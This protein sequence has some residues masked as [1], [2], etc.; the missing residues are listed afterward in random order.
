[1][2]KSIEFCIEHDNLVKVVQTKAVLKSP[3][4]SAN[5]VSAALAA[6]AVVPGHLYSHVV[7]NIN[8]EPE[9]LLGYFKCSELDEA[10]TTLP[11]GQRYAYIH[12]T[13]YNTWLNQQT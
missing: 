9:Y 1:M 3:Y 11:K 13:Q 10:T 4:T 5:H 8:G 12:R 6:H 2:S 7:C